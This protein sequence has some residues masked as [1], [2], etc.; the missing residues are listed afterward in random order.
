MKSAVTPG[1]SPGVLDKATEFP[2]IRIVTIR[3]NLPSGTFVASFSH[4]ASLLNVS[5]SSDGLPLA[6]SRFENIKVAVSIADNTR[7]ETPGLL[8]IAGTTAGA[9]NANMLAPAPDSVF[10]SGPSNLLAELQDCIDALVILPANGTRLT[11]HPIVEAYLEAC[12]PERSFCLADRRGLVALR[13]VFAGGDQAFI[14]IAT[15]GGIDRTQ[16]AATGRIEDRFPPATRNW[17][18]CCRRWRPHLASGRNF[19]LRLSSIG[20]PISTQSAL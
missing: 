3:A 11:P 4:R 12:G 20:A 6:P 2:V 19:R 10:T 7:E 18:L 15:M 9:A 14:S 17:A 13:E 1:M 5:R 16:R 8:S